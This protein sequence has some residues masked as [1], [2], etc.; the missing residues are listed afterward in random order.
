MD[1]HKKPQFHNP[2]FG[3][4]LSPADSGGPDKNFAGKQPIGCASIFW[5]YERIIDNEFAK[6]RYGPTGY[7]SDPGSK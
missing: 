3:L 6:V 2:S 5:Q 4:A 1:R 7:S